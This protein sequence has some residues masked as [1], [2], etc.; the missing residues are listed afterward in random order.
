VLFPLTPALS[1][2][3]RESSRPVLALEKPTHPLGYK[4]ELAPRPALPGSLNGTRH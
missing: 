4:M 2:G 1:R 3:E